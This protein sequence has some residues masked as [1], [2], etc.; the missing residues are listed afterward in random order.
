LK[1]ITFYKTKI[2]RDENGFF[3]GFGIKRKAVLI[4]NLFTFFDENKNE[5]FV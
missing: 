2:L 4:E 3:G 5:H 1:K